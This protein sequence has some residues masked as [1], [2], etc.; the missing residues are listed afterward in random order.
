MNKG[1]VFNNYLLKNLII[2]KIS[3]GES[4]YIQ[5]LRRV[6]NSQ[7]IKQRR[8]AQQN[9]FKF[10]KVI[11]EEKGVSDINSKI[12]NPRAHIEANQ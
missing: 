9:I 6:Y 10:T 2:L 1:K 11:L 5:L 12:S 8:S 7:F 3:P 4:V